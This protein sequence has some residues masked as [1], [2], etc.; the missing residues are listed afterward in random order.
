MTAAQSQN[1]KT[2]L[3]AP[4][5][6]HLSVLILDDERFD[7]HRIARLCSGLGFPCTINNAQTLG[8]FSRELELESYG[9]ILLDY[10]LPD[11]TGLEALQM[12]H[13]SPRNLNTPILMISGQ[14]T[15]EL[16]DEARSLGCV[17]YLAKDDLSR[18]SFADAVA[19]AIGSAPATDV[20]TKT[21][22]ETTDMEQLLELCAGTCARDIKP[23]V[24]R[25]MR[26]MR[27]LR[28]KGEVNDL[29]S[30]RAIEQNCLSLWTF[31]TEKEH[32]TGASL[33]ASLADSAIPNVPAPPR[34]VL[35]R[36]P[37]VFSKRPQ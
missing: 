3:N 18:D 37:S 8:E 22:F 19:C 29:L 13:L 35:S 31:L 11:G 20:F 5:D 21:R 27:D 26:Q 9:L 2:F 23:M 28:A 12:V 6:N 36:P 24:S 25:L 32:E 17:H 10:A 34:Q 4:M 7:R 15:P 1:Y 16:A 30:V 14:V 33:M